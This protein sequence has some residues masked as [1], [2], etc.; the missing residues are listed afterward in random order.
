MKHRRHRRSVLQQSNPGLYEMKDDDD[1]ILEAEE[2]RL[3]RRKKS[4]VSAVGE[5]F[6]GE[7][8]KEELFIALFF[9]FKYYSHVKY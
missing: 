7:D 9:Y 5:T 8:G 3:S 1:G 4:S 2:Q 6:I